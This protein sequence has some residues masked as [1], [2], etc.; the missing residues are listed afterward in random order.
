MPSS[1][2]PLRFGI[3]G[4][5]ND[6]LNQAI[7]AAI[8]RKSAELAA[9]LKSGAT[10]SE[11]VA[12]RWLR[13]HSLVKLTGH[14]SEASIR[15]L[16]NALADAWAAGGSCNQLVDAIHSVFPD[17][18]DERAATIAQT[19]AN[20]A[21]NAGRVQMA[22][23]LGFQEKSWETESGDPCDE[24]QRQ[25]AAGWIP[26]DEPFPGG[27]MAPCLHDGC[28]C[29]LAFRKTSRAD[30]VFSINE[31]KSNQVKSMTR[32][33]RESRSPFGNHNRGS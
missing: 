19:T 14:F 5:E 9:E 26:I 8:G 2:H 6:D 32:E 13:D 16:R 20:D 29:D 33:G 31:V 4:G 3:T 12:G 11:D 23:G 10:I 30:S 15:Q 18:S 17:F 24:C 21:Y 22:K 27:V 1:L 25:I 28:D 7:K